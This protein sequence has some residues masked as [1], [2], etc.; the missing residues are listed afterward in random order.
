MLQ[1][2]LMPLRHFTIAGILGVHS[3][4]L[5]CG[6]SDVATPAPASLI[7]RREKVFQGTAGGVGCASCHGNDARGIEGSAS[8]IV[9]R[10]V[11]ATER[12][13]VSVPQM[14]SISLTD[15]DLDAVAAYLQFLKP[16]R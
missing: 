2:E 7:D 4:F 6:S 8:G 3:L 13:V 14:R 16:H 11:R 12:A 5:A 15:D 10:P 1:L 9:G